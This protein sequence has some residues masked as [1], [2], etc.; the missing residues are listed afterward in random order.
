MA[1]RRK[2]NKS[3]KTELNF[4]WT[5]W[6]F[7]LATIFVFVGL[8]QK[9][10]LD[11]WSKQLPEIDQTFQLPSEEEIFGRSNGPSQRDLEPKTNRR[12]TKRNNRNSNEINVLTWNLNH[13]GQSKDEFE[14]DF[15]AEIMRDFD[16]VAIQEV[17]TSFYGSRA[18]SK[19][20]DQLDRKGNDWE[21]TV[22]HSTSGY[23]TE[24]Y[25]IFWNKSKLK[26]IGGGKLETRLEDQ[27]DREPMLAKFKDK[28]GRT[29]LIANY[30]ARTIDNNPELEI[31]YFDE[32]HQWYENENMLI[33]GDFNLPDAHL[34]FGELRQE[35]IHPVVKGL[36]TS[37]K[38]KEINGNYV[39][40]PYDNIYYE[41]KVW[42]KKG[43]GVVD[44]VKQFENLK[45]AR[46]ISDHLPVWTSLE[47]R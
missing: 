4:D 26:L 16:L 1:K 39:S 5:F 36:K 29:L 25:A 46:K 3:K 27:I 30:H 34:V 20:E 12:Q 7:V 21:H 31:Q 41:K 15:I 9:H 38:Q 6:R 8:T 24:R 14:I 42:R 18:A 10:R 44:F 32:L 11:N 28:K 40:N 22:S 17:V 13:L 45:Q 2:S 43:A 23:N 35:G 37:L 19:L 47:W 33:C